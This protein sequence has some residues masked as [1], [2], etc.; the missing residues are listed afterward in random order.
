MELQPTFVLASVPVLSWGPRILGPAGLS[1]KD[2]AIKQ[3]SEFMESGME[4]DNGVSEP[5]DLENEAAGSQRVVPEGV[6]C[7]NVR[8]LRSYIDDAA[9]ELSQGQKLET[10][11]QPNR[12]KTPAEFATLEI[13]PPEAQAALDL[14][15][16]RT[17]NC[18]YKRQS[19]FEFSIENAKMME[20]CP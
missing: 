10:A 4:F 5:Q 7:I 14:W 12:P 17:A 3:Q 9:Y 19:K 13:H 18:K 11:L 20:D 1:S 15:Q 16:Q 8:Y 2:E 6:D